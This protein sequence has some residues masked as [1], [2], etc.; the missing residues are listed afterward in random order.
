[1]E[2]TLTL[3]QGTVLNNLL[4]TATHTR[5]CR[6][7]DCHEEIADQILVVHDRI[8]FGWGI[9]GQHGTDHSQQGSLQEG[10]QEILYVGNLCPDVTMQEDGKLFQ[11]ARLLLVGWRNGADSRLGHLI[12]AFQIEFVPVLWLHLSFVGHLTIAVER[13]LVNNVQNDFR[14]HITTHGACAGLCIGIVGSL[15][16]I[17]DGING[18]AVEDRI[19]TL[20]EQP[21]T[22]EQLIDIA[23]W[24]V[25]IDDDELAFQSLFLQEVDDLLSI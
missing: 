16:E 19:A 6:H 4:G 23:G 21:Q 15:L 5:E 8:A 2:E 7:D 22:V 9:A 1:M 25:D 11:Y 12:S 10:Y 3:Q 24:L 18:I 20:V 17:S 13:L 14:I